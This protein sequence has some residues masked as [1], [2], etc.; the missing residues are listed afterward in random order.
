MVFNSITNTITYISKYIIVDIIK[1]TK[2]TWS[3]GSQLVIHYRLGAREKKNIFLKKVV[4]IGLIDRK[5]YM[6]CYFY[7][8]IQL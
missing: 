5:E 4:V 6:L 3:H 2:Q 1:L 7:Q 8:N